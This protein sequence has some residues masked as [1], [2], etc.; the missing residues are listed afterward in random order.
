MTV[1]NS[2]KIVLGGIVFTILSMML[3][4]FLEYQRLNDDFKTDI[5]DVNRLFTQQISSIETILISL[6]GLHHASDNLNQAELSSFS[7][8]MLKAYP[9]VDAIIGMEKVDKNTIAQFEQR[10]NKQGYIN[11]QLIKNNAIKNKFYLP[12]NF[13]EPMTPM[14]ASMLGVDLY[15]LPDKKSTIDR[16]IKTGAISASSI[17]QALNFKKPAMLIFKALYLG[18]YPPSTAT[19]RSSMLYGLVAL[20]INIQHFMRF[21]DLENHRLEGNIENL[22]NATFSKNKQNSIQFKISLS[23]FVFNERFRIYGQNY[24]LKLE[25]DIN[26]SMINPETILL[27]WL[28]AMFL[29]VLLVRLLLKRQASE[30]EI[31]YLAYFDSLTTLPNRTSFKERLEQLLREAKE[32]ETTGAI[33]FMDI[34]EF[35]RINDTLGHDVGDEL[36]KQVSTRLTQQMRQSDSVNRGSIIEAKNFV[37]RLGGDEFTLLL[38]DIKNKK[39]AGLIA[40]RIL[41]HISQPFNLKHHEVYIT[42]SIGIALF[43]HDGD[44]VEQLLKHADIA[45]YHA[46]S[47]GKNNYQF[48][49]EQMSSHNEQRLDLELKLHQA[50]ENQ[51]FQLHYQPQ[52]DTSNNKIV[53]AEALIRWQQSDL[54]MIYPDDFISLAE[55]TGQIFKIGEWVI[56]EACRQNK[57]WQQAGLLPVRISVN[58]SSLQFMQEDLCKTIIDILHKTQLEPQYLEIEITESI[59]M[60]NIEQTISIIQEL[61]DMGINVSVDDFGTGYSSLSYLKKFPLE[62]LK[63]DRSFVMDIPEDKDDMMITS[64]IISMAK[65]LNL[66]VIAEGVESQGQV[67]FLKEHQCD[68]M[69]G[70]YFSRPV[71]ADKFALLL[72]KP[73][74]N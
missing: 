10:M 26:L 56:N 34:D 1:K 54:G 66:N 12:I 24:Q 46:K 42:S 27:Y 37:T 19:E 73:Y 36:L 58:L 22:F 2:Y 70:Y 63:I 25:R 32:H 33:L 6:A 29:Y 39:S 72:T 14:S 55:E 57:A 48:Y 74:F 47:M 71:A 51:E 35:K 59:M 43:P 13:V 8:Q 11:L 64:A 50:L 40:S 65:S 9:F 38:T 68:L 7:E 44:N 30:D 61:S 45:M 67:E 52:I 23:H 3:S 69:Q 20:K 53:A 21:L 17:A 62:S 5:A 49:L 4:L 28:I 60:R 15:S 41:E 18:R 31:R 16:A